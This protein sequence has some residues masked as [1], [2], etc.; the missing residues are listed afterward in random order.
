MFQTNIFAKQKQNLA[1]F[2]GE[3]K[4]DMVYW[5]CWPYKLNGG[6]CESQSHQDV[7]RTEDH[8]GR[9]VCNIVN[10]RR[11]IIWN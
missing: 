10:I 9:V 1:Q 8:V 2:F 5:W 4:S 7:D 6:R 11:E 3:S